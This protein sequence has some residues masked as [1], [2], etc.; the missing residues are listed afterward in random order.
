MNIFRYLIDENNV[1][2]KVIKIIKKINFGAI[3]FSIQIKFQCEITDNTLRKVLKKAKIAEINHF[4]SLLVEGIG[5][6]FFRK[7]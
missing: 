2:N 4:V 7:S 5:A 6:D 3:S 1:A